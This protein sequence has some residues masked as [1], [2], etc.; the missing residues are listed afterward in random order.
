MSWARLVQT[1]VPSPGRWWSPPGGG[2]ACPGSAGRRS[3]RVRPGWPRGSGCGAP[4]P[5]GSRPR[6]SPPA[7]C[8]CARGP[9]RETGQEAGRDLWAATWRGESPTLHCTWAGR[10]K[11]SR[12]WGGWK[13]LI[14]NR[15]TPHPTGRWYLDYLVAAV[16]GGVVQG[17][18]LHH[19]PGGE[20]A[21]WQG[22]AGGT[23]PDQQS[24]GGRPG[25]GGPSG[26]P[27]AGPS[28]R[29]TL[30]CPSPQYPDFLAKPSLA[31]RPLGTG[32]EQ[33]DLVECKLDSNLCRRCSGGE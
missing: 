6:P 4:H 22:G 33:L 5:S 31:P 15:R 16:P 10:S 24:P 12:Y 18:H 8:R 11:L 27:C 19:V 32:V 23:I 2:P 14:L 30:A 13:E 17:G 3:P 20:L 25:A 29:Q 9:W 1:D 28:P 26:R 21:P 7:A